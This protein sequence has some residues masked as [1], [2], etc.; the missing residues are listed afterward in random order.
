MAARSGHV[1]ILVWKRKKITVFGPT[2]AEPN[3]LCVS[4]VQ[5]SYFEKATTETFNWVWLLGL[6]TQ[7]YPYEKAKTKLQSWVLAG[8]DPTLMVLA[9]PKAIG[10][11]CNDPTVGSAGVRPNSNGTSRTQRHW[12]LVEAGPKAIESCCNDLT[13]LFDLQIV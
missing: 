5:S 13:T 11:C 7:S 9:G 8:Q 2:G 12:V 10:S 1:V 6:A 4:I 3:S